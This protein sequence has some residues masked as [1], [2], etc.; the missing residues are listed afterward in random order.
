MWRHPLIFRTPVI[1]FPNCHIFFRETI[2]RQIL[3]FFVAVFSGSLL[4]HKT[5]QKPTSQH[6]DLKNRL[7]FRRRG[8]F[9]YKPHSGRVAG[10]LR[11]LEI[12]AVLGREALF[13]QWCEP[14]TRLE[15]QQHFPRNRIRSRPPQ[16][17]FH[18]D[19]PRGKR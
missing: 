6:L 13:P 5:L 12:V 3:P 4:F 17:T 15:P 11:S 7:R 18:T 8:T 1:L 10:T 9:S 2:S 16:Q 14:F 19:C